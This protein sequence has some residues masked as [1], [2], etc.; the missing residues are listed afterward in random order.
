MGISQGRIDRHVADWNARFGRT[1]KARWPSRL[2]RHESLE[3]AV[4]VLR[5]GELRSRNDAADELVRDVAPA[6]IIGADHRAHQFAR[7]YFRPKTPTQYHIE[8]IRKPT[9]CR[10]PGKHAPVLFMFVFR[11]A[12]LMIRDDVRFSNGNMQAGCAILD[13]DAGFDALDFRKIYHEGPYNREDPANADITVWRCAE[14]LC[15]S[16]LVLDEALEGVVCRSHAERQFL[17]HELGDAAD[18]WRD[19]I[20]IL[21]KPGY[22]NADYAFVESVDFQADGLHVRFHPR[23]HLPMDASVEA[24][25]SSLTDLTRH[26]SWPLQSLDLRK[27]WKFLFEV[28]PDQYAVEISVDGE[29]AY[30]NHTSFSLDPF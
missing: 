29:V 1:P 9:E 4:R 23:R 12:V 25:V 14:V 16:P 10:F 26:F 13:G 20:K 6:E 24:R 11:S 3:N 2:F 8:G 30:R 5:S 27:R 28:V 22:F 19:R 21:S 18:V 7:L 15:E 17:L